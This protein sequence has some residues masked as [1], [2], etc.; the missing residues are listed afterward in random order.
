MEW[1]V[2]KT[3]GLLGARIEGVDFS[4]PLTDS[5]LE[6]IAEALYAHQVVSMA[7]RDMTPE[8]H[9]HIALHFGELEEHAT[10]Q[11]EVASMVHIER[12]KGGKPRGVGLDPEVFALLDRWLGVRRERGPTGQRP[13]L[14]TMG[15]KQ[16][17]SS[18]VRRSM[19]PRPQSVF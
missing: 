16:L 1:T 5:T 13:L 17:D 7:A 11:F 8:Q 4:E 14:C 3:G 18:P 10:D 15:G 9:E 6:A 2:T 19:A 12:G